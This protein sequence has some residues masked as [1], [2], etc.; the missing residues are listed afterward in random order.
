MVREQDGVVVLP[1]WWESWIPA[2]DAN[3][4]ELADGTVNFTWEPC[5]CLPGEPGHPSGHQTVRCRVP[6]CDAPPIYKPPH[7]HTEG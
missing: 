7:R 4:H 2:A 3:G 6:G 1:D 5:R